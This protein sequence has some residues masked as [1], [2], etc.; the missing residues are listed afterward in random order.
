MDISLGGMY[1]YLS[2]SFCL[3]WC[4]CSCFPG[5]FVL[6]L[7][8]MDCLVGRNTWR[9]S[10]IKCDTHIKNPSECQLTMFSTERSDSHV[11]TLTS[12]YVLSSITPRV[13]LRA[14][15]WSKPSDMS[16][17]RPQQSLG[18]FVFKRTTRQKLSSQVPTCAHG[19]ASM[20]V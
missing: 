15:S 5:C 17:V 8:T 3:G 14:V 9:T 6:N 1:L 10:L 12:R 11:S 2:S 13:S 16:G 4:K 7:A 18:D 20:V 19:I